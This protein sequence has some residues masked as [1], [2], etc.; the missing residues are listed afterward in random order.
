MYDRTKVKI[1]VTLVLYYIIVVLSDVIY[2]TLD[3]FKQY[4]NFVKKKNIV[5][6]TFS[7]GFTFFIYSAFSKV[8][9]HSTF[10]YILLKKEKK[11]KRKYGA[12]IYLNTYK[13]GNTIFKVKN[14]FVNSNKQ[15]L[16]CDF[17]FQHI[18]NSP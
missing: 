10:L 17:I 11:R 16:L 1:Y 13:N 5:I 15:Y 18:L 14:E 8:S 9:S 4:K 3:L 2:K 6:S 7:C 12:A